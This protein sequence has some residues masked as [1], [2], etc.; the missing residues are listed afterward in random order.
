MTLPG[1]DEAGQ[2]VLGGKTHQWR[3]RWHSLQQGPLMSQQEE[4]FEKWMGFKTQYLKTLLSPWRVGGEICTILKFMLPLLCY[5][6]NMCY[7]FEIT[8][9][10]KSSFFIL[11]MVSTR[12]LHCLF[13]SYLPLPYLSLSYLILHYGGVWG[14]M[15]DWKVATW[16]MESP[17]VSWVDNIY[18]SR[19][20]TKSLSDQH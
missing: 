11:K 8:R 13:S 10:R 15:G 5:T 6:S 16:H 1:P 14:V 17:G 12:L 2:W 20:Y 9:S 3:K 4:Y 19:G 18:V 7:T